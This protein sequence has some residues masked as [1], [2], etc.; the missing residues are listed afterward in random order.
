[1][2]SSKASKTAT[3]WDKLVYHDEQNRPCIDLIVDNVKRQF[4]VQDLVSLVYHGPR[5]EPCNISHVIDTSKPCTPDNVGWLSNR[6]RPQIK[7]LDRQ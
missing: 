3:G 2:A 5:A 6:S 4:L 1:M 7:Q